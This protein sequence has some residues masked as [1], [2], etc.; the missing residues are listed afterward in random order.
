MPMKYNLTTI[1]GAVRH[2]YRLSV[3]DDEANSFV[4]LQ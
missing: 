4:D 3:S 1:M 2:I